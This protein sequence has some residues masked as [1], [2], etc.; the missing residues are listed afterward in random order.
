MIPS[1]RVTSVVFALTLGVSA[2]ALAEQ[3]T[4]PRD[5]LE[6]LVVFG[7]YSPKIVLGFYQIHDTPSLDTVHKGIDVRDT[8]DPD[9]PII[10]P[11]RMGQT[12]LAW[13]PGPTSDNVEIFPHEPWD[14]Y[15]DSWVY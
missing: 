11:I 14:E 8:W 12:A 10:V 5:P 3:K 7:F 15:G 2:D 13:S 1:P 6:H 9:W 4:I